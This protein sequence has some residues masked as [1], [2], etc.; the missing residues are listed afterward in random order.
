MSERKSAI[1]KHTSDMLAVERH[2]L[3]AIERQ[4]ADDDLREYLEANKVVIEIERV[5]KGHVAALE[6]LAE[7][8]DTGSESVIKKAVTEILGKAAGLYDKVRADKVTRMLR[9]DYTALSLAAMAYTTYHAFGL[10]IKEQPIADLA[11]QHLKNITPLLVE[12]SKVIPAV[13]VHEVAEESD[14][15]VDDSVAADAVRNT[16]QAWSPSVTAST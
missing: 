12:I 14:F 3:E 10:A 15:A 13:A 7:R 9:D 5:L 2:I 16:Q 8:Y 6:T 4:R 11:L 1:Q